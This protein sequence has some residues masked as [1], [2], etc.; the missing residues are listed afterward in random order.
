MTEGQQELVI[1]GSSTTAT[2]LE[3]SCLQCN[4]SNNILELTKGQQHPVE[5]TEGQQQRHPEELTKVSTTT[6]GRI[7]RCSTSTTTAC[8]KRVASSA[9]AEESC[10]N[11]NNINSEQEEEENLDEN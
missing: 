6:S 10:F 4:N 3:D 9:T 5:L 7:D 2:W 11:C 1:V 8:Q